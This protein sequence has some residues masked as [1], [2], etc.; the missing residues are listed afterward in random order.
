MDRRTFI[1]SAAG[2]ILDAQIIADARRAARKPSFRRALALF[3]YSADGE[4][5]SAARME[6]IDVVHDR[7]AAPAL[8]THGH[9]CGQKEAAFPPS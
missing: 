2:G 8:L 4:C 5:R 6:T 3:N 7:F 1:V 9:P